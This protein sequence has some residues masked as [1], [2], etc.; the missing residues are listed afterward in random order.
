MN[1]GLVDL[2]LVDDVGQPA[3]A[4]TLW[5]YATRWL[6]GTIVGTKRV[7]CQSR[8]VPRLDTTLG[9]LVVTSP[10]AAADQ[11]LAPVVAAD[12]AHD[13]LATAALDYETERAS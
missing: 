3:A 10:L 9:R 8:S 5:E 6:P 7:R 13:V 11:G 12:L 4:A 1:D 2:T